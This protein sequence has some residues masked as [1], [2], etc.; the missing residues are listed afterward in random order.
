[1]LAE[2][3]GGAARPAGWGL[4]DPR[5]GKIADAL[6]KSQEALKLSPDLA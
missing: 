2:G 3:E 6:W 1:V 5:S 4:G